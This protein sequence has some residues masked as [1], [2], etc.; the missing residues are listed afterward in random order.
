M[1]L[2]NFR[3]PLLLGEHLT[4]FTLEY[5]Y[6]FQ[7]PNHSISSEDLLCTLTNFEHLLNTHNALVTKVDTDF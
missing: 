2:E 3:I 4:L 6:H 5:F 7:D 1:S